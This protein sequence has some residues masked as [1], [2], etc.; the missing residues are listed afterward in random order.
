MRFDL[1]IIA[2]LV[3]EGSRVLDLG[4]G[5]GDLLQYLQDRRKVSA[6]GIEIDERTLGLVRGTGELFKAGQR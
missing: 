3:E 2:S 4:C 1:K 6:S 5:R